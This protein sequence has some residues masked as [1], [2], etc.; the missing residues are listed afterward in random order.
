[1]RSFPRVVWVVF[2]AWVGLLSLYSVLVPLYQAPDEPQHVDL[3]L[4]V[5]TGHRYPAYDEAFISERMVASREQIYFTQGALDLEAEAAKPRNQ[6]PGFDELGGPGP[7]E[8]RNQLSA[9]PP[10][11]S[12][13]MAGVTVVATNAIPSGGGWSWDETVGLLRLA[14]VVLSSMLVLIAFKAASALGLHRS[15]A[16]IASLFPLA[17]PELAHIGSVVNNDN[18]L[19]VAG[20]LLTVYTIRIARGDLGWRTALVAGAL[21]GVALLTKGFALA[22]PVVVVLAYAPHLW[23]RVERS[24][25]L[26][27]LVQAGAVALVVGGWW[28]IANLVVHGRLLPAIEL[29][30]RA[31]EGFEPEL[32]AWFERFWYA[33]N[34]RYWGA[35]GWLHVTIESW[36]ATVATL[37]VLVLVVAAFLTGRRRRWALLVALAPTA[38]ILVIVIQGTWSAYAST[39]HFPGMQGRYLFSGVVGLGVVVAAG[40]A[41]I[42]RRQ[43]A[44]GSVLVWIGGSLLHAASLWRIL[45]QFWGPPASSATEEVR[46]LVAFSPWPA[47]V[48]YGVVVSAIVAW[49]A[50]GAALISTAVAAA[51]GP[52]TDAPGSDAAVGPVRESVSAPAGEGI[53]TTSAGGSYRADGLSVEMRGGQ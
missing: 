50:L 41:G 8:Y 23:H 36:Q 13:A 47:P 2:A 46:A 27:A 49:V 37:A 19:T 5:R 45:D 40:F 21:T 1:M 12:V 11:Y 35:F 10:L 42:L 14:N 44:W 26:L 53:S 6:R 52:P 43:V 31:A 32:G 17:I 48:T 34:L 3:A 24:K 22:F 7:S 29:I 30:P 4:E 16:T 28:W 38:L 15:A 20:A 33:I 18:L 9:H 39:A 25:A 51:P